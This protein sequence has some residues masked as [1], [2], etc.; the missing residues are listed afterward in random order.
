MILPSLTT[1]YFFV[2]VSYVQCLGSRRSQ[3]HRPPCQHPIRTSTR[4]GV[5]RM[6]RVQAERNAWCVFLLD[7]MESGFGS[8]IFE[9]SGTDLSRQSSTVERVSRAGRVEGTERH[10]RR[11]LDALGT[12]DSG[13]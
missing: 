1:D 5:Q 12:S 11:L 4:T 9:S 2:L 6:P 3:K 10:A 8:D 7:S 13:S